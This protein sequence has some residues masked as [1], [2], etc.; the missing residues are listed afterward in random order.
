MRIKSSKKEGEEKRE[1]KKK[2]SPTGDVPINVL[3]VKGLNE[4][5]I[6]RLGGYSATNSQIKYTRRSLVIET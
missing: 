2:K 1:R 4:I 5:P 6:I 3:A